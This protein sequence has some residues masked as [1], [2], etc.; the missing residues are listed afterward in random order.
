VVSCRQGRSA[1]GSTY[2]M[3]HRKCALLVGLRARLTAPTYAPI[4]GGVPGGAQEGRPG[5]P[6][7]GSHPL[8]DSVATT[9]IVLI[10]NLGSRAMACR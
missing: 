3:A 7:G 1:A 5:R 2:P 10:E 6:P 4:L 8:F 9:D